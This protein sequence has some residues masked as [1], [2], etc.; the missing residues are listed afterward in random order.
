MQHWLLG[1]LTSLEN[2]KEW[3]KHWDKGFS[4][5]LATGASHKNRKTVPSLFKPL[6]SGIWYKDEDLNVNVTKCFQNTAFK[7]VFAR[8]P[9]KHF[10]TA[11]EIHVIH[12]WP[13]LCLDKKY[14]SFK[15]SSSGWLHVK[16][17]SFRKTGQ[18]IR[19]QNATFANTRSLKH[20]CQNA[21][22]N[23]IDGL[24]SKMPCYNWKYY[25]LFTTLKVAGQSFR[26]LY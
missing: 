8:N 12:C 7:I 20:Q 19:R 21:N 2:W 26:T 9:S 15:T 22:L 1:Q 17:P 16:I 14:G 24:P 3:L 4:G 18:N 23:E 11:L 5:R 25:A 13:F 10:L 6:C